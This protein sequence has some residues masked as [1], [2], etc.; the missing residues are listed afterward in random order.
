MVLG[1]LTWP[2][3]IENWNSN[4]LSRPLWKYSSQPERNTLELWG[5]TLPWRIQGIWTKLW[6]REQCIIS[7]AAA[8]FGCE[9][10]VE[11]PDD[12]WIKVDWIWWEEEFGDFLGVVWGR[13]ICEDRSLV[14]YLSQH[15]WVNFHYRWNWFWI[16][17]WKTCTEC[18]TS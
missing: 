11:D 12:L 15:Q 9:E 17:L 8:D 13:D 18:T 10:A 2:R 16:L 6:R 3:A 7:M 1:R 4:N 5:Y 14:Y